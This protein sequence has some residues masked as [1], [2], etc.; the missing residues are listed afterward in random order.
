MKSSFYYFLDLLLEPFKHLPWRVFIVLKFDKQASFSIF[1]LAMFQILGLALVF[2]EL[3][4]ICVF[5]YFQKNNS[6]WLN[7]YLPF[8]NKLQ[9]KTK[10]LF[11]VGNCSAIII[12]NLFVIVAFVCL[13]LILCH[14]NHSKKLFFVKFMKIVHQVAVNKFYQHQLVYHKHNRCYFLLVL[15]GHFL[16]F[17]HLGHL[18]YCYYHH[19]YLF[20]YFY[21]ID[22]CLDQIDFCLRV[23]EVYQ[24]HHQYVQRGLFQWD[25]WKEN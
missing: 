10:F 2:F 6:D 24:V 3:W 22:C 19:C 7:F 16:N 9:E 15:L 18:N 21:P 20:H 11:F 13:F 12:I 23:F 1:W 17:F 4:V 8:E 5:T 14:V 25:Y